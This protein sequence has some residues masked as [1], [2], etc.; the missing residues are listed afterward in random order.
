MGCVIAAHL[1]PHCRRLP[2]RR[3]PIGAPVTS[4]ATKTGRQ[5]PEMDASTI[6]FQ[7]TATAVAA[8]IKKTKTKQKKSI[9]AAAPGTISSSTNGLH[10]AA[11]VFHHQRLLPSSND[12][13]VE[14]ELHHSRAHGVLTWASSK[15]AWERWALPYIF[16]QKLASK[17][18]LSSSTSPKQ[19][20]VAFRSR[21]IQLIQGL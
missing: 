10:D 21:Y 18:R 20:N 4:A 15:L 9:A 7:K 2:R 16:I 11:S 6:S 19:K 3:G 5:N 14:N 8:A 17:S 12:W 13:T 1:V